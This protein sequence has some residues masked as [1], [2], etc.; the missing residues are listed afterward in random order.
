MGAGF[1]P[2]ALAFLDQ[3]NADFE[4]VAH[5]LLDVAAD[6]TDFGEFGRLDLEKGRAR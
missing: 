5:D 1:E 3:R 6:I 4:E 2:L